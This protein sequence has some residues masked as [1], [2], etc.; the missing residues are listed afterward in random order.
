MDWDGLDDLIFK[1]ERMEEE[2]DDDVDEIVKNNVIEMTEET[3]E[4]GQ[5]VFNRG[6]AT[7]F[8]VGQIEMVKNM[9]MDYT[10]WSNS[11]HSGKE[12]RLYA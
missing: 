7:G 12:T 8:T 5:R 10:M 4:T 1:F 9:Q 3:K 2:I 6:Y 11:G